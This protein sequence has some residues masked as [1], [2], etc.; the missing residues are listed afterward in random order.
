MAAL[1]GTQTVLSHG[2]SVF[3]QHTFWGQLNADQR[4][5]CLQTDY[6]VRIDGRQAWDVSG[7]VQQRWNS[8]FPFIQSHLNSQAAKIFRAYQG[9]Q[10]EYALSLYMTGTPVNFRP[11][12]VASCMH[13]DIAERI[14]RVTVKK[15]ERSGCFSPRPGFAY[16]AVNYRIMCSMESL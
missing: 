3:P 2:M 6:P 15:C 14:I 10:I 4:R 1:T 8:M 12:V 7:I 5:S 16:L 9:R 13:L 11:T